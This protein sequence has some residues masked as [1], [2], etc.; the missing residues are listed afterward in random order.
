[1]GLVSD[2][3]I[4]ETLRQARAV[5]ADLESEWSGIAESTAAGPD[6]EHD[7]EG[8]TVGFERARV[9]A[10]L[11]VARRRLADLEQIER[12]GGRGGRRCVEC[13][14]PIPAERLAALP[15]T[16]TCVTCAA[17]AGEGRRRGLC[18]TPPLPSA[19]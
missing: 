18:H 11:V 1:M 8:S 12:H 10:L 3:G 9:A 13:G 7:A 5:V 6:D 4:A 17:S 2:A 15:T 16:S 19:P 14:E